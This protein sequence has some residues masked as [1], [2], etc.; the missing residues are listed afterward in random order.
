RVIE[1]RGAVLRAP[2]RPLAVFGGGVVQRKEGVEERLVADLFGIEIQ[3]DG[4]CM[5]GRVS[6]DV[7][8]GGPVRGAALIADGGRRHTGDG[9]ECGLHS[10]EASCRECG[11]FSAHAIE[12]RAH[13]GWS[14]GSHKGS[15]LHL[16]AGYSR[17]PESRTS[18]PFSWTLPAAPCRLASCSGNSPSRRLCWAWRCS[19]LSSLRRHL[20][21]GM[22]PARRLPIPD[23]PTRSSPQKQKS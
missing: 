12:M 7:T 6:A 2:I 13:R 15:L 21:L 22:E 10:P 20:K 9:G 14:P 1:D 11:L 4:L 18:G 19:A 8:I 3:L 23:R 5:A 17:S 16:L